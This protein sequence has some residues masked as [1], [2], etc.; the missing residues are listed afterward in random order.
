MNALWKNTKML[1]FL[2]SPE[3][4]RKGNMLGGGIFGT[5]IETCSCHKIGY[6]KGTGNDFEQIA[7]AGSLLRLSKVTENK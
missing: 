1:L 6:L 4:P 2:N 5:C 3:M 7:Y